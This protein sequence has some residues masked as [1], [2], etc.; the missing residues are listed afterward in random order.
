MNDLKIKIIVS[1]IFNSL[2][3]NAQDYQAV[4]SS[5]IAFFDD[6]YG[7]IKCVRIDSVKNYTD[8]LLFPFSNIQDLDYDCFT[9]FGVSWI[10]KKVII[11]SNGYNV[12]FNKE[13]DSIKIKTN[14]ILNESWIAY[15]LLDSTIIK[16]EVIKHDTFSFL[17]QLDS[18]KTIKFQVYNKSMIPITHNLNNMSVLLSKKF[19]LVKTL[20]FVLFPNYES[21]YFTN[22]QLQE[23]DLIGL[24]KPQIGIQNLKW[25]DVFDFQVGDEIHVLY[26]KSC[27]GGGDDYSITNK[28]INKYLSRIDYPDSIIYEI[29]VKRSEITT[30]TDTSYFNYIHKTEKLLIKS[31]MVFDKLPGEPIVGDNVAFAY[32]M[33][34]GSI[35]SKTEP[36]V[37]E[38]IWPFFDDTCWANC[39]ADGCFPA[40]TYM[41]GLGGPYYWCDNF[42]FCGGGEENELVFYKK[43]D[44]TW[45]NPL[46]VSGI[47]SLD[48]KDNIEIFPN[49]TKENVWIKTSLVN[50]PFTFILI[51]LKGQTILNIQISSNSFCINMKDYAKGVYFY[52]ITCNDKLLKTGK[53]IFK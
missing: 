14:A 30:R 4:R 50:Y 53:I 27:W 16:A 36:S 52:K 18:I 10:G 48:F 29:E 2:W 5:T 49:P 7:D 35:L 19:G 17:G 9:P 34:N 11:Q 8:S 12:F 39:C 47:Q 24:S 28:T 40:Y 46:V 21:F 25:F 1:L 44:K 32:T 43:G 51:D 20:N 23:Y 15:K 13:H 37:Y 33:T 6:Q 41:K 42:F 3:L 45:G 31:N 22:K 38:Q 26:N